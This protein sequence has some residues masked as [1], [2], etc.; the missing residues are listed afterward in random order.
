MG[1]WMGS[2]CLWESTLNDVWMHSEAPGPHARAD[3]A[4]SVKDIGR[5]T[6]GKD[7]TEVLGQ[8]RHRQQPQT[9]GRSNTAAKADETKRLKKVEN[10][11]ELSS[12]RRCSRSWPREGS[13][14]G[15]S[16]AG[17]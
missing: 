3:G 12:T 8:S 10:D 5:S 17:C 7:L 16:P 13:D 6:R 4:G 15:A 9:A 2:N 11:D 1:S 14:P